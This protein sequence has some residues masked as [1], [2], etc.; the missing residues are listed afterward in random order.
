MTRPS[1]VTATAR[2]AL[3]PEVEHVLASFPAAVATRAGTMVRAA[4][5]DR[6]TDPGP[7]AWRGS[8]LTGDGFPVEVAFSTTDDRL[9]LTVEPGTRSTAPGDRLDRVDEALRRCTGKNLA[10]PLRHRLA[11]LQVSG[12]LRYGAWLGCRVG[13]GAPAYKVYAEVPEG[14]PPGRGWPVPLALPDRTVAVR[15]VAVGATGEPVETYLRVP[16]LQPEHLPAVL[17]PVGLGDRSAWLLGYIEEVYG[18]AVRDRVPGPS[19]GISYV[20]GAAQPQVSLHLYARAVWGGDARI[21]RGFSR[22]AQALGWD[23]RAYEEVSAPLAERD[24]WR[25]YH[26]LLGI[27]IPADGPPALTIGLRPVVP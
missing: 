26:G 16:S 7:D 17:A 27:T 25:T 6:I 8:R 21:R 23:A 13:T 10:D 18:H 14:R 9:R 22:A 15:M 4:L 12:P 5:A 1:T 19:V 11:T 2:R 3:P 20:L 24:E